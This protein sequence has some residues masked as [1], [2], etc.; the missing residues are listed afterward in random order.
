MKSAVLRTTFMATCGEGLDLLPADRR[1]CVLSR[2]P[3]LNVACPRSFQR[4]DAIELP[5]R[6]NA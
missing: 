1:R 2:D 5:K 4:L 6:L 3:E